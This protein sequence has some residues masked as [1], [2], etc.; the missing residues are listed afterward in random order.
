[1]I[2]ALHHAMFVSRMSF[3][4][5]G[6]ALCCGFALSCAD[7]DNPAGEVMASSRDAGW[8]ALVDWDAIPV[9]ASNR[10]TVLS[11]RERE[12][13]APVPLL[14]PGNRDFNNFVAVCGDRPETLFQSSDGAPC[15]PGIEG[16]VIAS[17]TGPGFASRFHMTA[18]EIVANALERGF[19]DE[20]IRIYVDSL[21][22]P[23]YAGRVADLGNEI[24]VPFS[25]PIAGQYGPAVVS[26]LPISYASRLLVV[27]DQLRSPNTLYYFQIDTQ[28]VE[29][30]EKFDPADLSG[31][32]A[33]LRWEVPGEFQRDDRN[34]VWVNER[35]TMRGAGSER[36]LEREGAGTLRALR[37][38]IPDAATAS[39]LRVR[40]TWDGA[41]A[42]A[43]DVPLDALFGIRQAARSFETLGMSV[44]VTDELE[45]TLRLP[46][47]H[48]A[49]AVIDVVNAGAQERSVDVRVEG[50]PGV[51]SADW[52]RFHAFSSNSKEPVPPGSKHL[53]LDVRGRGKYVGTLMASRG[54]ADSSSAFAD[55]MN[56]LEGDDTSVI[57]GVRN[58]GTG[59]EDYFNGAFYFPNGPFDS[60]FAALIA[61]SIDQPT[62]S[63]ALTML[64]WHILSDAR[65]FQDSFRL[66]FEYGPDKP[67]TLIEYDSVAFYYMD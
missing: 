29:R 48:A 30:T 46:M 39:D 8:A 26:Y 37:L 19:V 45:L 58:Q 27:L 47:P 56:F 15:E 51:P 16:Y 32:V 28:S 52:G 23:A 65:S 14:A 41:Q 20:T 50:I 34:V 9:L 63:A 59:T 31:R 24:A 3:E 49:R 40:V 7:R 10:Y 5:L 17:A 38:T 64:R 60:A 35:R 53:V 55:P 54:R 22:A 13:A 57:D 66:E 61:Q 12:G 25:T 67:Q 44:R 33:K 1:L 4:R 62:S 43:V 18:G 6:L 36:F 11:S 2:L 21:D 42:P